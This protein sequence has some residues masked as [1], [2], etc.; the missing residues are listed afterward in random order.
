MG[1]SSQGAA[2]SGSPRALTVPY[3]PKA[4]FSRVPGDGCPQPGPAAARA[5]GFGELTVD[6]EDLP[7][8]CGPACPVP[9][10]RSSDPLAKPPH[11]TRTELVTRELHPAGVAGNKNRCTSAGK[12]QSKEQEKPQSSRR[13]TRAGPRPSQP[14][15]FAPPGQPTRDALGH[16]SKMTRRKTS[17]GSHSAGKMRGILR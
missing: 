11:V 16:S 13:V 7:E 6:G 14:P 2:Y 9:P 8:L 15:S 3:N 4:T 5:A 17:P 12:Q 10:A 1:S